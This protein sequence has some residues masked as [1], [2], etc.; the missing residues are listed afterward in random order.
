[1]N[2]VAKQ[3]PLVVD[4]ETAQTAVVRTPAPQTDVMAVIERVASNPDADITKLE[5]LIDLKRTLDADRARAEFNAAFA[6]MQPKIPVIIERG[7]TDKGTYAELEDIVEV[8]RPILAG[9]G[10]ALSHK[11]E[12]PSATQLRVVGI[13][14]H[15]GGHQETSEFLSSGDQSGS[16]NAIQALGSANSYGR[17]YTTKDLLN[18]VTRRDDD[19][20]RSS[21]VYKAPEAPDG[22]E[23][24]WNG[25]RYVAP[26][27]MK[28]LTEVF[29]A[30]SKPLRDHLLKHHA[31]DWAAVK[32]QAQ[33]AARS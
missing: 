23:E 9:Y 1:M 5:R 15:R 8:I 29:N 21:E 33:K 6:E 11:T 24:F 10:F 31:K 22:F 18:I 12:W 26:D 4:I 17:R 32:N 13:L 3:P 2:T 7:N 19:D 20:G 30:A 16:K 27:G 28:R 14:R 25:L